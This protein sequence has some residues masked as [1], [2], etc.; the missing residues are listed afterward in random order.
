[1]KN[2]IYI[3]ILMFWGFSFSQSKKEK[4]YL[5]FEPNNSE[6]FEI[7]DGSGNILNINKYRKKTRKNYT[8]FYILEE[9]FVLDKKDKI[10]T[11]SI[12]HI[13][14]IKFE[15]LQTIKN[16]RKILKSEYFFKNSIF[17]KIYLIERFKDKIIKYPV[18]WN[19]DLIK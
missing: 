12:K 5:L 16:K 6:K 19:T 17:K 18:I 10:D 1:M 14:K 3:I 9:S 13:N 7:K 2:Y 11:C 8:T 15:T 4:I